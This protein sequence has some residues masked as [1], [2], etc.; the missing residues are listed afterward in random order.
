MA[1]KKGGVTKV[2]GGAVVREPLVEVW[3]GVSVKT[4]VMSIGIFGLRVLPPSGEG[5]VVGC[6]ILGVF[7]HLILTW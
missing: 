6:S 1:V 4:C 5:V 2:R 3:G 7:G